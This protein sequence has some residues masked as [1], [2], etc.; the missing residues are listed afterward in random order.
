[1]FSEITEQLQRKIACYFPNQN[2]MIAAYV[3]VPLK[4]KQHNTELPKAHFMLLCH[5]LVLE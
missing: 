2:S 1:L 4:K 3:K 5:D